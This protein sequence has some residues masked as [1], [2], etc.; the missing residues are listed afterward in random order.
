M[1]IP[2][3]DRLRRLFGGRPSHTPPGGGE[4]EGA[5]AAVASL[6]CGDVAARLFDYMD[7]ELDPSLK[8]RIQE[9]LT[10]GSCE[11]RRALLMELAFDERVRRC[12]CGHRA[13]DSLKQRIR[14]L[15]AP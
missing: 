15:L 8:A 5:E 4:C 11:C 1:H 10:H 6:S 2:A 7:D 14:T 12:V 13:P 9:H 3:F